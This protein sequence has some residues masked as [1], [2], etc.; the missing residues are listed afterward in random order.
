MNRELE[1]RERGRT[2]N[3]TTRKGVLARTARRPHQ[4]LSA[5]PLFSAC[6]IRIY[7]D[8]AHFLPPS[9]FFLKIM[10]GRKFQC[11]QQQSDFAYS[12]HKTV[13]TSQSHKRSSNLIASIHSR[14]F[15]S[16]TSNPHSTSKSRLTSR[17]LPNPPIPLDEFLER[18]RFLPR[19]NLNHI[20]HSLLLPL[21]N[22]RLQRREP[23]RIV[24]SKTKSLNPC[25]EFRRGDL[26]VRDL[27]AEFCGEEVGDLLVSV[28]A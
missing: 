2:R 7:Q 10:Q 4:K 22:P 12:Q 6:W 28:L 8:A 14:N 11:K 24:I 15:V 3:P 21:T 18:N 26:D 27:A 20:I 16:F 23:I 25:R 9:A 1:V 13:L 17:P 5:F 19:D